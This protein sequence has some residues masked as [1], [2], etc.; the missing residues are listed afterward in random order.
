[1]QQPTAHRQTLLTDAVVTDAAV[2]RSGWSEDF[3][4]VA[5]L[6]LDD[7]VVD[8]NVADPR[9]RPLS[10]WDVPIGGLCL[11]RRNT[12]I[13]TVL[14]TASGHRSNYS[15]ICCLQSNTT[16]QTKPFE[17]TEQ[18]DGASTQIINTVRFLKKTTSCSRV[19]LFPVGTTR[20]SRC[21]LSQTSN[22]KCEIQS[23]GQRHKTKPRQLNLENVGE[24]KYS[25][26]DGGFM[27]N[28]C[29]AV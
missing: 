16:I 9:W 8:L 27:W 24:D 18:Q 6:E 10:G 21:R 14:K 3:A 4:G 2:R 7:L 5:I 1:M 19:V 25:L 17:I 11:N 13:S 20:F 23:Q 22:E 26:S 15:D 12:F 28:Q 29:S